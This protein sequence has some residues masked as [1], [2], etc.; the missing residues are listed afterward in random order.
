LINREQLV[1]EKHLAVLYEMLKEAVI[2]CKKHAK[3]LHID[4][5]EVRNS[6]LALILNDKYIANQ[7]K[8]STFID[9]IDTVSEDYAQRI[10]LAEHI[11]HKFENTLDPDREIS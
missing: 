7:D 3:Q 11:I 10:K 5:S 2:S 6:I 9:T 4:G 1:D 8:M